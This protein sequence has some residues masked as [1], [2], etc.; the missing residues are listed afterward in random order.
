MGNIYMKLYGIGPVV[1]KEMSFNNITYLELWQPLCSAD[2]NNLCNLA[3]R[4]HEERF[5]EIILNLDPWFRR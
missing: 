2:Q 4:F 5:C 1:Q 3:R